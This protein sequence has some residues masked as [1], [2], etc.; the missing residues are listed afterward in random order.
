M[1][2]ITKIYKLYYFEELSKVSKHKAMKIQ[3]TTPNL[4]DKVVGLVESLSNIFCNIDDE[5]A[6]NLTYEISSDNKIKIDIETSGDI[7]SKSTCE[8]LVDKYNVH[9][10]QVA[11]LDNH[12]SGYYYMSK[13]EIYFTYTWSIF[14][15]NILVKIHTKENIFSSVLRYVI[16]K[17]LLKNMIDI[18]EYVQLEH[19]KVFEN[20]NRL[21]FYEDGTLYVED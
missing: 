14:T 10:E 9:N 6:Y 20:T 5:R 12:T 8:T 13:S 16:N 17:F 15:I 7:I 3:F 1:R 18:H 4:I 21:E 19:D 11:E 2:E